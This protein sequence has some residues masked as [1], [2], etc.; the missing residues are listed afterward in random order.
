MDNHTDTQAHHWHTVSVDEVAQRLETNQKTGLSSAKVAERIVRHGP[1][2]L[3]ETRRRSPWHMLLD[4]FTEFM[5]L[6]LI[7]AS[8]GYRYCCN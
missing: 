4:Q 3:Q 8:T 5:I 6:V 7:G 1:N 2:A